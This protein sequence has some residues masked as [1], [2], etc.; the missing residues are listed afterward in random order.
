MHAYVYQSLN[1]ADTYVYLAGRDDFAR[2]PEP[3][4][5]QMGALQFVLDVDLAQRRQLAREDPAVVS[6]NLAA[7]GFHI[8]F[9]PYDDR[10]AA[11]LDAMHGDWGTDA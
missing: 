4:R 2:L 7:R 5:S 8:Q 11:T 1:K 10:S 9:P 3:I 6:A